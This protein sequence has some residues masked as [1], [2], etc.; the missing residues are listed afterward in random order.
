VQENVDLQI[1]QICIFVEEN[2]D[3]QIRG[4]GLGLRLVL[5]IGSGS[6]LGIGL[7]LSLR[8]NADL[9]IRIFW[10][11]LLG[12]IFRENSRKLITPTRYLP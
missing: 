5:G 6:G 9:R 11:S 7:W 10:R 8:G 1:L 12:D 3:P 2:A 4:L